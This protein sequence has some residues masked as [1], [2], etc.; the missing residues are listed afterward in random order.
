MGGHGPCMDQ[1]SMAVTFLPLRNILVFSDSVAKRNRP[2]TSVYEY[3]TAVSPGLFAFRQSLS[4]NWR[5][6]CPSPARG[7]RPKQKQ[8]QKQ[9]QMQMQRQKTEM[10]EGGTDRHSYGRIEKGT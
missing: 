5:C 4:R 6:S 3:R 7:N 9:Q 2:G 8:T 1:A 10:R